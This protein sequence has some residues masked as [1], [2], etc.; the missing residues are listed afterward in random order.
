M[1]T[2]ARNSSK[3][4]ISQTFI[5]Y[6]VDHL[7]TGASVNNTQVELRMASGPTSSQ[8]LLMTLGS[9]YPNISRFL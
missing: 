5:K 3:R 7:R 4:G 1:Q 9:T 8:Q 2:A 6:F